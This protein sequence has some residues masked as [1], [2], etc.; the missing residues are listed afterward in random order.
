MPKSYV[1]NLM[2]EGKIMPDFIKLEIDGDNT[3]R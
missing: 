1:S 3:K 2:P